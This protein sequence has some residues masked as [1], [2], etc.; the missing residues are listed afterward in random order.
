[1]KVFLVRHSVREKPDD[2]VEAEDGDPEAELTDEGEEIATALGEW[3][4]EN[5]EIPSVLVISPTVRAQ[6]T[7][8]LICAAI[9]EAGFVPPTVKVDV[10]IG[11]G[12]SIRGLVLSLGGDDDARGVGIVSHRAPIVNGLKA[13]DVDNKEQRK[14]DNP[15]MGELRILKVKRKSGAWEEKKRV[16]PSDLV[17]GF[18]DTYN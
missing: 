2:F 10:G 7:A 14:V 17:R 11:P 1:M 15:A 12:Q 13:L 5:D 9:K 16:R 3:M 6:Q 4:A 18:T 8:D